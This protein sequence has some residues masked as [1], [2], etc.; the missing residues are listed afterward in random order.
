MKVVI[1]CGGRGTR[2]YRETELKP[3]PM[4]PVGEKPILIHIM[5]NFARQGFREFL[6]CLGYK[7]EIIRNYFLNFPEMTADFTVDLATGKTVTH[8]GERYDWKV[9]LV[10]TGIPTGT[11]GRIKRA[12]RHLGDEPFIMTYGDGLSDVDVN[13]L[14]AHHREAGRIATVTGMHPTSRFGVLETDGNGRVDGFQEKPLLKG[15]VSGASS[16]SRRRSSTTSTRSACSRANPSTDW[17]GKG[18]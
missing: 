18:N 11:G 2:L 9:T 5:E 4:V 12:Q 15:L 7:G 16:S 10:N 13:A 8:P 1:L 3:K 17:L 14:T 6:L